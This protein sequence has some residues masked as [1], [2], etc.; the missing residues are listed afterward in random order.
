VLNASLARMQVLDVEDGLCLQ[1]I[2]AMGSRSPAWDSLREVSLSG[3]NLWI[4]MEAPEV[5]QLEQQ[6]A[7]LPAL[8]SK[9]IRFECSCQGMDEGGESFLKQL[10]ALRSLELGAWAAMG[11]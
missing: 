1:L 7:E 6:L 10:P 11:C 2:E 5:A 9:I 4:D 3:C 8:T